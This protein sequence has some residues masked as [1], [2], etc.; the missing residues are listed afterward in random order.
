MLCTIF[1]LLQVTE[2]VQLLNIDVFLKTC[3]HDKFAKR[4]QLRYLQIDYATLLVGDF[5]HRLLNLRWL[6]WQYSPLH[7]EATNFHMKKLVILDLSRSRI[8]ENWK[9]WSQ[10]KMASNLKVLDISYTEIRELPDEIR[11]L[12]K[13]KIIDARRSHLRGIRSLPTSIHTLDLGECIYLE[14]LPELP[15]SL[16]VLRVD[17]WSFHGTPNLANLVNLQV[18]RCF[19]NPDNMNQIILRD[20][21][22]LSKLQ[23]L[24]FGSSNIMIQV[25][26][27]S[28]QDLPKKIDALSQLKFLNLVRLYIAGGLSLEILPDL[29]NLKLLSELRLSGCNKLTKIQGLG[30]LQSLTSLSIEKCIKLTEIE[31][32]GNLELL[33][34]LTICECNKLIGI[35]GLGNL[36]SLASFCM[37]QCFKIVELYLL[38]YSAPLASSEMSGYKHPENKPDRSSLSKL[39]RF[40]VVDC[41]N[42]NKIEGLHILVS[43][44][45]LNLSFCSSMVRMPNLSNLKMLRHLLLCGCMSLREIEGLEALEASLKELDIRGCSSLEKVPHLPNTHIQNK[46]FDC[47]L[48]GD[49]LDIRLRLPFRTDDN[50]SAISASEKPKDLK[51][52]NF[53]L[54][55][56]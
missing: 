40:E 10:I 17:L 43:L 49:K 9:G 37:R 50:N 27:L 16:Q 52:S 18:L 45:Y 8:P 48:P 22:K 12:K 47:G 54:K 34:S 3:E 38:E 4:S 20:I 33:E 56:F 31:G 2:K 5:K 35:Q 32:L 29:S 26:A 14:A 42:L 28:Q 11:M 46:Q 44:K 13:L 39:K 6:R 23:R 55:V 19:L 53:G 21:V 25:D 51:Y 41:R 30:K 36:V 15:S 1:Q 7:F 24:E